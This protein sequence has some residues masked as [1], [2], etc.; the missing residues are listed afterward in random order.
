MNSDYF[1]LKNLENS[2][3]YKKLQALWAHEGAEVMKSMTKAAAKGQES[4]WRYYAGQLKGFELAIGQLLRALEE[5][6]KEGAAEQESQHQMTAEEILNEL[7][8]EPKQ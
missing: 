1:D 6:E 5:M 2:M 3:G 8:G 7:R 4:A